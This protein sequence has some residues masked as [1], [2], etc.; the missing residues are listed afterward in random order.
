MKNKLI[1]L[2]IISIINNISNNNI[3]NN[4]INNN[5][6]NHINNNDV[7]NIYNNN[8]ND[9]AHDEENNYNPEHQHQQ[10][11]QQPQQHQQQQRQLQ[12]LHYE[13][14]SVALLHMCSG[15][16]LQ[17]SNGGKNGEKYV[18]NAKSN[19]NNENTLFTVRYLGKNI[20]LSPY[21]LHRH[22]MLSSPIVQ[23]Q[24]KKTGLCVCFGLNGKLTLKKLTG[25]PSPNCLLKE[26]FHMNPAAR[27]Y[28]SLLSDNWHLRFNN[29]GSK[30]NPHRQHR[31]NTLL[32]PTPTNTGF[33]KSDGNVY[34]GNYI[35]SDALDNYYRYEYKRKKT[36]KNSTAHDNDSHSLVER[37]FNNED[38]TVPK[39]CNYFKLINPPKALSDADKNVQY[40][41]TRL[42][43][44]NRP[45]R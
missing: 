1:F 8:N 35:D 6:N 19:V 38:Q 3:N 32:R 30:I 20:P 2:I 18:I 14:D 27:T 10:K 7:D 12:P 40:F 4:N 22:K 9:D 26:E 24:H 17:V 29:E 42:N 34:Y 31:D 11:Q 13:V 33:K 16:F 15:N 43:N 25:E 39:E 45:T 37:S 21:L 5:I 23:L 36:K 41:L 44:H 28:T